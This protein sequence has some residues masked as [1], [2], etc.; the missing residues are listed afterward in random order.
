MHGYQDLD[1]I[2]T[3]FLIPK[4]LTKL[5]MPFTNNPMVI[6]ICLDEMMPN[7]KVYSQISKIRII[8]GILLIMVHYERI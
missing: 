4:I 6:Y 5:L 8:L 3:F 2:P 7:E 1:P